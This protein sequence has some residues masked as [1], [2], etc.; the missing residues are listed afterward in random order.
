MSAK[1][2][3]SSEITELID[4]EVDLQSSV[5]WLGSLLASSTGRN[6]KLEFIKFEIL[7]S[8]LKSVFGSMQLCEQSFGVQFTFFVIGYLHTHLY[9]LIPG[10]APFV[11]LRRCLLN[12]SYLFKVCKNW[13][14]INLH[15]YLI[16]LWNPSMITYHYW[17]SGYHSL[18]FKRTGWTV[19][20]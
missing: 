18:F 9:L 3:E 7:N 16:L 5:C 17:P 2:T 10:R 12:C 11:L 1:V 4:C 19:K 15:R 6:Y 8:F 20:G 14:L 13:F